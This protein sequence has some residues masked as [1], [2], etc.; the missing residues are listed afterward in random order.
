MRGSIWILI[1]CLL[2]I[3]VDLIAESSN[4]VEGKTAFFIRDYDKSLEMLSRINA[5]TEIVEKN[6]YLGLIYLSPD[7]PSH[8]LKAGIKYLGIA[9]SSG[10]ASAA[11]E[12]S[13]T[14]FQYSAEL[15]PSYMF[16]IYW[17]RESSR[18]MYS[19]TDSVGEQFLSSSDGLTKITREEALQTQIAQAEAGNV[20]MKFSL[21]KRFEY[22]IGVTPDIKKSLYWYEDAANSG[23][24]TSALFLGYLFCIG[25]Y[26]ETDVKKSK[27]WF[28]KAD[29]SATCKPKKLKLSIDSGKG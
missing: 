10:N 16:A 12:L 23:H 7:Y 4:L 13:N 22:G 25:K 17:M 21:A 18:L 27:Y 29:L 3:P 14:Y 6:Y 20:D 26:F 28:S 2:L 5:T 9:A 8:N 11:S 15:D 1:S 19:S 24:N